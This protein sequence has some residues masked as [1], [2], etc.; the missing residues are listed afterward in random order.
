MKAPVIAS[1]M[2]THPIFPATSS[3]LR[4]FS[5]TSTGGWLRAYDATTGEPVWE[6]FCGAGVSAPAISYSLGGEQFIAVIAAGSR[7]T[8]QRGSALLIFGLGGGTSAPPAPARRAPASVSTST[9][10][11]LDR[12]AAAA[13]PPA[14][15][16]RA[17]P[18]LAY[19]AS[20]RVAYLELDAGGHGVGGLSFD[21]AVNGERAFHVPLG[22]RVEARMRNMD[23]APHSARI[24]ASVRPL[25]LDPGPAVFPGAE[26]R[27]GA[28]G[29]AAG[30]EDVFSFRAER[31][32]EFLL[33]CAVPGH[34]AGG[35]YLRFVVSGERGVP[36]FR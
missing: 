35:M 24:V 31:V 23:A 6:F 1:S 11:H 30:R 16:T 17:G 3:K 13:W 25:P 20:A 10:G 27:N 19:D 21:G 12:G 34:A 26:T 5:R 33:A 2:Y 28:T 9:Q 14:R 4:P 22:W 32:G 36:A 8:A 18:F 15:A 29:T 7:Y